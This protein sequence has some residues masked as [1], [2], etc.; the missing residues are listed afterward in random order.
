MTTDPALILLVDDVPANLHVLVAAL[1]GPHRLKTATSGEAALASVAREKPDLVLL[2]VMMPGLSGIDVMRRLRQSQDTRDIA[3]IFVSAD[4]SEQTQL[5][6]LELGADDYLTK[7]VSAPLLK[8]RVANLLAR[9][10]AEAQLR[11]AAHVF[12]SSGEAIMITDK[13]NAIVEVNQAFTRLTGYTLEEVRGR[14][15]ACLSAGRNDAEV[16]RRMWDAIGAHGFWQGELWDRDKAGREYPKFLNVS[17]VR[18][19]Y[20]DVDFHIASFT[21]VSQRK[22]AEEH[23]RRLAHHDAL[24]GLLNRFSLMEGLE[25]AVALA[26]RSEGRV[27]VLFLDLDRFKGIN[28]TLGH[29]VGDAVLVEVARRLGDC[30]RDGDLVARWGGDEFIVVLTGVTSIAGATQV[31]AKLLQAI[32]ERPFAHE[33]QALS[34]SP[35]IGVAM[36]PEDGSEAALLMRHADIAMY[37]A[38]NLGRQNFQF[39]TQEMN[40]AALQ[41]LQLEREL[42]SGLETGQ[43]ELHYQPKLAA[44]GLALLG[45]EA[46]LRWRHPT[47]GVVGPMNFI[48]IA[49]E[50]GMIGQIGRWVLGEACR[51]VRAWRDEF[52]RSVPVAINLSANQLRSPSLLPEVHEAMHR[53]GLDGREIELEIT[54]SVAMGDPATCIGQLQALRIMG[55]QLSID[56]FGTGYSS[57]A[58]L[59]TLPVHALKLD[60]TFVS[61]I[62]RDRGD[63][64]ICTAAISLAHGLGLTVVAEGVE[65]LAQWQFLVDSGCDALQGFLL[66]RPQPAAQVGDFITGEAQARLAATTPQASPAAIDPDLPARA[67]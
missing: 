16:H 29:A 20:G 38:K 18:N 56:D 27:A 22:A 43:F 44:A 53:H 40:L 52:G 6:G 32:G 65:T 46:L 58:Y 9:K 57:L 13:A 5:A 37:H 51:Q 1:K 19:A 26:R 41:R 63:E 59:K 67:A 4:A 25:Q 45:F 12:E 8:L 62:G 28:D 61:D 49:E 10:R 17:V 60:K 50:C 2:D 3:V 47:L 15:P 35:S 54:E 21:D 31:A 64:V 24:T 66:G 7:P 11:L 48:P 34:V 42:R 30:T 55:V 39:F 33:G 36:Y 14:D 23:I